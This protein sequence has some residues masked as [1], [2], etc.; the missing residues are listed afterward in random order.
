MSAGD[1]YG[2]FE[3]L[4]VTRSVTVNG[5]VRGATIHGG[6]ALTV[7]G[8]FAGRLVVED[9]AV[10]SVNGA[11][12]PGDVSNDGVIMVAGVTGVAFSQLDDMGTFAVAVGSLVEHSKVV[13]EDGSLESF[14]RGGDLTVDSNRLCIWVSEQRRFVPQAQM[15]A[16]IEAGQR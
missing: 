12:E 16:D 6:A 13:H 3:N 9:D 5:G 4:D 7:N 10:L 2:E 15:Q 8:A 14:V 11:F 1:L